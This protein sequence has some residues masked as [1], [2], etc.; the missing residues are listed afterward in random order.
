M[1]RRNTEKKQA[2]LAE[3]RRFRNHPT[4]TEMTERLAQNGIKI[5]RAT[6]FRVLSDLADDGTIRRVEVENSDTRYDGNIYPHYHFECRICGKV[7]DL[8]LPYA[9][10]LD[11]ILS[12]EGYAVEGHSAEFYGICPTCRNSLGTDEKVLAKSRNV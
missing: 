8:D 3:L 5:S 11:E 12:G 7:E 9:A 4:A 10:E 2:I 6:V 1:E